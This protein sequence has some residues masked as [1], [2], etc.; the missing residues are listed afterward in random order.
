MSH[1][2]YQDT[3]VRS[4]RQRYDREADVWS[5]DP[6]LREIGRLALQRIV[7]SG[8]SVLDLGTGRGQD[9]E[10][11][12]VAGHFVTGVDIVAIPQAEQLVDLYPRQFRYLNTDIF[13]ARLAPGTF[14]LVLDNGCFH[15]QSVE[16]HARYLQRVARLLRSDG[17]LVLSVFT[18]DAEDSP[19]KLWTA[20]DGRVTHVLCAA[21]LV[22]LLRSAG[23]TTVRQTRVRRYDENL[24]FYL[25][26]EGLLSCA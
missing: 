11:F 24:K 23:F 5:H 19:S 22:A 2:D 9:A 1:D 15:H 7:A 20:P 14:D 21:D 18:R 25:V 8:A 4:F 3:L 16:W 12:C 17:R 13:D 6:A 26:V 10:A